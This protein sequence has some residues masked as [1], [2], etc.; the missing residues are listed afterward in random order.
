MNKEKLREELASLCHD[1]SSHFMSDFII[2]HFPL[3]DD[4]SIIVPQGEVQQR[5]LAIAT[6][7]EGLSEQGKDANRLEADKILSVI[8]NKF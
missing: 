6:P 3:R 4:G 7:Y 8:N 5:L 1:R 2:R